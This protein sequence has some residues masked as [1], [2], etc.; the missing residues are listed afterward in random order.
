MKQWLQ[1]DHI[2]LIKNILQIFIKGMAEYCFDV[3]FLR[4][5]VL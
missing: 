3:A 2:D 1:T 5:V 4:W